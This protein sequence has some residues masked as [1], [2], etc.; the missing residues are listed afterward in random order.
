MK[1]ILFL[2]SAIL[3]ITA[4]TLQQQPGKAWGMPTDFNQRIEPISELPPI[5]PVE[6]EQMY[7]P[8]QAYPEQ[9]PT[10]TEPVYLTEEV[11]TTQISDVL[12]PL[13]EPDEWVPPDL[14]GEDI[15]VYQRS[16]PGET[17]TKGTVPEKDGPVIV[18]A[19]YNK[20][21]KDEK[22]EITHTY[23]VS[24]LP[25]GTE[26][27]SIGLI[28]TFKGRGPNNMRAVA[29]ALNSA[30]TYLSSKVNTEYH[31]VRTETQSGDRISG[32]TDIIDVF[33]MQSAAVIYSYETTVAY[34][35]G[36]VMPNGQKTGDTWEKEVKVE[37]GKI[38]KK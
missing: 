37:F 9:F 24:S 27:I 28:K 11:S 3:L 16:E 8:E 17:S 5:Y 13:M 10:V 32:S 25:S 31:K 33:S 36:T 26:I 14:V 15:F 12:P 38:I 22:T 20:V 34:A 29:D 7:P 23:S 35:P 18:T 21:R 19:N 30:A 4:C 2:L 6:P 1:K